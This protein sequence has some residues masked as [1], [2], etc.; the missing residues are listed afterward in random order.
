VTR[1]VLA[2][3]AACVLL[4][5]GAGAK[6]DIWG[7]RVC[8]ASG[9][10]EVLLLAN[11]AGGTQA[12]PAPPSAYF[13]ITYLDRRGR[14]AADEPSLYYVPGADVLRR[15]GGIAAWMSPSSSE[16]RGVARGLRPF[17][18]PRLTRVTVGGRPASDPGSYLRLY[19]L[20]SSQRPPAD[21]AGR[22]PHGYDQDELW[23]YYARVRRHWI[24]VNLWS[25]SPTPWGDGENFVWISRRGALLKRDDE[26]LQVPPALAERVRRGLSLRGV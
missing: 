24:P 8:G 19:E 16:L 15:R 18:R 10:R 4:A 1:F 12:R 21:P 3:A 22:K 7:L 17:P 6:G 13:T 23:R 11:W 9:C 14:P 5:P 2:V 25:A 26:L 20:P